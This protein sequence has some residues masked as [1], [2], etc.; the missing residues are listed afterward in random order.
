MT[1]GP[2]YDPDAFRRAFKAS[3]GDKPERERDITDTLYESNIEELKKHHDEEITRFKEILSHTNDVIQN[4]GYSLLRSVRG[5][6]YAVSIGKNHDVTPDNIFDHI[7]ASLIHMRLQ[8]RRER[9]RSR[10]RDFG[11]GD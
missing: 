4:E 2:K 9:D 8:M 10:G 6:K 1:D 5:I 11:I 3:S 7:K